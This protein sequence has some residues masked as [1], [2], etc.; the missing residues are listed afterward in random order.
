MLWPWLILVIVFGACVGSFINVVIYRVPAGKS[1]VTPPSSCPGCGYR[2][3]WFDN[4]PV[5]A[6]LWLGG[7]CRQCKASI[8]VQYPLIEAT[9]AG[10]FALL[11]VGYTMTTWRS[12]WATAP[13]GETW[14]V[15]AVH[16]ALAASLIAAT[17][18]DAKLFIIPLPIPWTATLIALVALP[19]SAA[20]EP[21]VLAVAPVAAGVWAG[22]AIGGVA[23]LVVSV[24]LL[25]LHLLPISF[26][27]IDQYEDWTQY[28]HARRETWKECLF[29]LPPVVGA[30][31]GGWFG[32]GLITDTSPPALRVLAGVMLGYVVGGAV[33]WGTRVLGNFAFGR[34]AMGL[35]D[36]H[37]MAAV[38]AAAGWIDATLAF[39]VAPFFGLLAYAVL[40]AMAKVTHTQA[41]VIP[42]GPYLAGA[43]IV[44]MLWREP[45]LRLLGIL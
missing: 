32:D 11:F 12:D 9:C 22:A 29:L 21:G 15:L 36:V 23:G 13:I 37:L 20:A 42:Y 16:L 1:I 35:G 40:L 43:S 3:A 44:A 8:S 25:Q 24:L 30:I 19:L 41:R 39:F 38:G 33:V 28:P 6:W 7:R 14:P 10:V 27:D 4:I 45:L 31:V 2:L 18:I 26:A 17:M 5:L 34:E